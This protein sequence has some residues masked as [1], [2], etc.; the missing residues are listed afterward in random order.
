MMNFAGNSIIA[1][2]TANQTSFDK[3]NAVN[4]VIVVAS[5]RQLIP[6]SALRKRDSRAG[7]CGSSGF[8]SSMRGGYAKS[9]SVKIL[10]CVRDRKT[11]AIGKFESG[12]IAAA[13]VSALPSPESTTHTTRAAAKAG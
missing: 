11:R 9:K 8:A 12:S 2:F 3:I 4:P 7:D 13:K 5:N 6:L 1:I 10:V